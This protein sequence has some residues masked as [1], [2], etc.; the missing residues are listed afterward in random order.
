[1]NHSR[2][3][4]FG[5]L[6]VALVEALNENLKQ[7]HERIQRAAVTALREALFNFSYFQAPTS[8]PSSS[9]SSET[10]S[11]GPSDRILKLTVSLYV[12]GLI[13]GE[14]VAITRGYAWALGT[15][16]MYLLSGGTI[17]Q[18]KDRVDKVLD[19]LDNASRE[20]ALVTGDPD[21]ETR[22]NAT[23]AL[24]E[25]GPKLLLWSTNAAV[26]SARVRRVADL[27]LRGCQ[28]YGVD[29][30]G[31]IGSWI[32]CASMRGL[33]RLCLACFRDPRIGDEYGLWP[34][35]P[36]N[37]L[38][39][40]FLTTKESNKVGDVTIYYSKT[41][42][43]C[44]WFVETCKGIGVVQ[45]LL[46]DSSVAV[47]LYPEENT[48]ITREGIIDDVA[49][50]EVNNE[51]IKK[52]NTEKTLVENLIPIQPPF[53]ISKEPL[54]IPDFELRKDIGVTIN[55]L[56]K[57]DIK[58]HD[59][60]SDVICFD[61]N[62]VVNIIGA[63]LKQLSEKL[64]AVR[65]VAGEGLYRLVTCTDPRIPCL[66]ARF[67]LEK[68]VTID[69]TATSNKS[70]INWSSPSDVFPR[71]LT[72][73]NPRSSDRNWNSF[74][75]YFYD[76]VSGIVISVGGLSESV[77]EES[78]K[79]LLEWCRKMIASGDVRCLG[80][81]AM[82]LLRVLEKYSRV[83]RVIIPT[84]K[85]IELLLRNSVFDIFMNVTDERKL[86]DSDSNDSQRNDTTNGTSK[87]EEM[88]PNQILKYIKI[89]TYHCSEMT[90]LRGSIDLLILL[91][92]SS[93]VV[94]KNAL[95]VLVKLVG[96]KYPRIRRYA[97]EQLYLFLLADPMAVQGEEE[98]SYDATGSNSL[99]GLL[100]SVAALNQCLELLVETSWDGEKAD[101]LKA[102]KILKQLLDIKATAS[103]N[104]STKKNAS[105][106][107]SPDELESYESLVRDAG[108]L[109][110]FN[111]L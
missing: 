42:L 26:I 27:L 110:T 78:S 57:K 50:S 101:A 45:E 84:F 10:S 12:E 49:E 111:I 82:A 40:R 59:I 62:L 14:N 108:E 75:D 92:G 17:D 31:D 100:P 13:K 107:T 20:N 98:K 94:R 11:C 109:E 91:V 69:S 16:P 2:C 90:K 19:V 68:L 83:D 67:R 41:E 60:S 9:G 95:S 72:L 3:N 80:N 87:Y 85:T 44:G 30:R 37:A 52:G 88:F 105:S 46:Y 61:E 64:D 8:S 81:L 77:V 51:V 28:D 15:L 55:N 54:M 103:E 35:D 89:E 76:V 71:L 6:Q 36:S 70:V 22:R 1:M 38:F 43:E 58:S 97:A 65:S 102:L 48:S 33:E 56:S 79:A 4:V 18:G 66:A 104:T 32:R 39:T 63:F 53:K 99:C 25:L 7:P 106:V 47:V 73:L 86:S 5:I 21:A 93:D 23:E 29:K 34:I 74:D 96:H 24:S